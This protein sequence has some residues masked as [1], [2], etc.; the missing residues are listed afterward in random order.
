MSKLME[1]A[2]G[3][4]AKAKILVE[5]EHQELIPT[6]MLYTPNGGAMLTQ[7]P[8]HDQDEKMVYLAMISEVI[9][10]CEIEFYVMVGEGLNR[11]DGDKELFFVCGCTRDFSERFLWTAEITKLEGG[12]RRVGTVEKSTD[13]TYLD[14]DMYQLFPKPKL[15]G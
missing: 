3:M 9:K 12:E 8:W 15:N 6:F 5:V 14:G 2:E 11:M 1:V 13:E 10:E 7:T 4:M